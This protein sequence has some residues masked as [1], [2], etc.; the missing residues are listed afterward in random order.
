MRDHVVMCDDIHLGRR[1][2]GA[3]DLSNSV[4]SSR[5]DSTG[6][7]DTFDSRGVIDI[8]TVV[9]GGSRPAYILG[10]ANPCR[11]FQIGRECSGNEVTVR[12]LR[13]KVKFMASTAES[14][15]WYNI[16]T[17]DVEHGLLSPSVDRVGPFET[18]E[19][20]L[21]ALETLRSNSERWAAEEAEEN[22]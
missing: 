10:A 14:K 7:T 21:H 17:G 11:D 12:I 9:W 6:G 19:L 8:V 1:H 20:A 16:R 5:G 22:R 18:R 4:K 13:H 15:Y 2:S 3:Q